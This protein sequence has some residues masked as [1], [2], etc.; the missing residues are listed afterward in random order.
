MSN[1]LIK[2]NVELEILTNKSIKEIETAIIRGLYRGLDTS[3]S[4]I[5][6]PKD[7]AIKIEKIVILN[8]NVTF[9]I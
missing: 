2:V 5:A 3:G 7:V 6:Q 9:D 8:D 1:R 4:Y